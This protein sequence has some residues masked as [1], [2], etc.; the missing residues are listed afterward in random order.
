[1]TVADNGQWDTCEA[2]RLDGHIDPLV[3][4][5]GRH[6]KR[7]SYGHG[8]VGMEEL[9]V[10]RW[11]DHNRLAIIVSAD[12]ARNIVRDSDIAVRPVCGLAVPA[13]HPCHHRTH[14]PAADRSQAL[15]TEVGVELIPGVA[16]RG[17]AIADM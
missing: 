5:E 6:D 12:P 13:R 17:E 11:I 4:D 10:D 16:H 8:V 15:G 7:L 1:G 14:E 9:G 3:G 2:A